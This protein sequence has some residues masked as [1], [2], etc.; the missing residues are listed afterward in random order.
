M[1]RLFPG[2]PAILAIQSLAGSAVVDWLFS[3]K[4]WIPLV[5]LGSQGLFWMGAKVLWTAAVH[6]LEGWEGS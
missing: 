1:V 2:S 5:L 4:L 3:D 6:R